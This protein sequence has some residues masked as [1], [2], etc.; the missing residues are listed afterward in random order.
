MTDLNFFFDVGAA[1]EE[2]SHFK[3]GERVV[4]N[5]PGGISEEFY[6]PKIAMSTGVSMRVNL[7]GAM[8]LE[9]YF[10]YPLEKNSRMVFGFNFLPGW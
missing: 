10:A 3:D 8:I 9:P 1:F 6:K 7:F 4:V 5:R 2:W